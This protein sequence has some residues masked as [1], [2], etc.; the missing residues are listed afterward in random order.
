MIQ[1]TRKTPKHVTS[2]ERIESL[3]QSNSQLL[4]A[5][6]EQQL[7]IMSQTQLLANLLLEVATLKNEQ[8]K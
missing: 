4:M 2:E 3:N 8:T 1:A 7:T 5:S 6:A